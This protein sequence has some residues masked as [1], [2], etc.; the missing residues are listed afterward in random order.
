MRPFALALLLMSV[1]F[2]GIAWG[3]DTAGAAVRN[4]I[5]AYERAFA[6]DDLTA[7]RE[8]LAMLADPALGSDDDILPLLVDAVADRQAYDAAIAALRIRTGL[9]PPAFQGQSHYPGYPPSDAPSSWR[10]WLSDRERARK[11]D[12]DVDRALVEAKEAMRAA[13]D[14]AAAVARESR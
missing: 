2:A 14:A 10:Y 5:T 11:Q 6:G 9:R 3:A 1:P 8:A 7:K 4:A 12:L 13:E